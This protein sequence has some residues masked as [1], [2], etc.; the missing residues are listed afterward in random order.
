MK[1]QGQI[2]NEENFF[3]ISTHVSAGHRDNV[4]YKIAK[5]VNTGY[6]PLL[7]NN[8]VKCTFL[9]LIYIN[10]RHNRFIS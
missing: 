7:C 10:K 1:F 4:L 8:A 6:L 5:I 9:L 3:T 2:L